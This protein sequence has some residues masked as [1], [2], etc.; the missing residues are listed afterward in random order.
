MHSNMEVGYIEYASH[1]KK[2]VLVCFVLSKYAYY[3]RDSLYI[4]LPKVPGIL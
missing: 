4:C 3:E 1:G 2:V